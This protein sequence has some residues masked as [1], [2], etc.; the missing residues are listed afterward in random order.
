MTDPTAQHRLDERE[1][2]GAF[3]W[4]Y[5]QVEHTLK[6]L[7]QASDELTEILKE[8]DRLT[9]ERQTAVPSPTVTPLAAPF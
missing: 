3:D 1:L 6:L 7:A 4:T 8:I 5:R 2:W 9:A